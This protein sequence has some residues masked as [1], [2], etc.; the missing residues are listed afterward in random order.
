MVNSGYGKWYGDV[1]YLTCSTVAPGELSVWSDDGLSRRH[2]GLMNILQGQEVRRGCVV[3]Y[4][5][6]YIRIRVRLLPGL[7][8]ALPISLCL[9]V[10]YREPREKPA[11]ESPPPAPCEIR[12]LDKIDW[13]GST[14]GMISQ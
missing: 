2:C 1:C 8:L 6:E 13:L 10:L 4:S 11:H 9:G 3:I 7:F 12:Q 14:K 5:S